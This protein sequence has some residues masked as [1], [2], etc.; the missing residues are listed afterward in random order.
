MNYPNLTSQQALILD[1][2]KTKIH[3]DGYPPTIREICKAVN[4][5]SSSSVH[6]HINSLE[7][8]G[9]IRKTAG[10]NRTIEII[11]N[12][13][14]A[15]SSLKEIIEIPILGQI[16][17]G[18]PALADEHFDGDTFPVSIE[19]LNASN[20]L[21]VLKVNGDS[22]IE[23]GIKNNDLLIVEKNNV[24]QNGDIVVALVDDEATVK[25]FYK[26]SNIIRLQP[27]NET[28]DPIYVQDVKIIGKPVGLFRRM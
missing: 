17:A 27:E 5:S 10:K 22:M 9:Y 20:P 25:T 26:E 6:A 16:S 3:Q 28:M 8:K 11:D 1:Y 13:S 7:Q 2:I 19:F 12:H 18:L 21:F 14:S 4:L 23:A 15:P 24:A